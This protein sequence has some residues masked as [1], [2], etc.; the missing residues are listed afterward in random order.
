MAFKGPAILQNI[1]EIFARGLEGSLK[2]FIPLL[3]LVEQVLTRKAQT[4]SSRSLAS[5]SLPA[6]LPA[7]QRCAANLLATL[8]CLPACYADHFSNTMHQ[9]P[10][11]FTQSLFEICLAALA[12]VEDPNTLQT[13]LHTL[14][15]LTIE[16]DGDRLQTI[17]FEYAP[18]HLAR[19]ATAATATATAAASAATTTATTQSQSQPGTPMTPT[20]A[21]QSM[22]MLFKNHP[23]SKGQVPAS[24][25]YTSGGSGGGGGGTNGMNY[26]DGDEGAALPFVVFKAVRALLTELKGKVWP[27]APKVS[28]AALETLRVYAEIVAAITTA[29]GADSGFAVEVISAV[30]FYIDAQIVAPQMPKHLTALHTMIV[31]GYYCLYSWVLHNPTIVEN[32]SILRIILRVAYLG[33]TGSRSVCLPQ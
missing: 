17:L 21:S 1:T 18:T 26:N 23:V 5:L 9:A 25:S 15:P 6:W 32:R 14:V 29:V 12:I 13:V 3:D 16:H 30:C 10:S 28:L 22:S 8:I 24:S 19:T 2:L 33:L 7:H 27:A 20:P 4:A 31:A 11:T